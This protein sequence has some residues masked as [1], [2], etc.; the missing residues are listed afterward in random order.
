MGAEVIREYASPPKTDQ[1]VQSARLLS[2]IAFSL[3]KDF[4]ITLGPG[5]R[6]KNGFP[7]IGTK[8]GKHFNLGASWR[9]GQGLNFQDFQQV[10]V[11]LEMIEGF[12]AGIPVSRK[13]HPGG[14]G[15]FLVH[16]RIPNI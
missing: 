8:M 16:G 15:Y 11:V 2:C 3:K 9:Q 7:L 13:W 5:S 6:L 1:A 10:Q 12:K 4:L 14:C